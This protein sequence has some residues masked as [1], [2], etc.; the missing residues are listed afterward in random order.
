MALRPPDFGLAGAVA[1]ITGGGAGLGRACAEAL[2]GCGSAVVLLERDT[3]RGEA[4]A[5]ALVD[6][7]ADA[8]AIACDVREADQVDAAVDAVMSRHGRVSHLVNNAGGTIHQAFTE[9]TPRR[10]ESMWRENL[11]SALLTTRAVAA[12]M[13]EGGAIVNVTTIEAHRAAPDFAVY[14]ACKSGLASLT[15]SLA[16]ELAPRIR[17]NA[18]APDLIVTE[19]LLSV[20][21]E[22]RQPSGAHIP[23]QR[24]GRPEELAHAVLFLLSPLSSYITGTT[25]HVDGGTLAAGGWVPDGHGHYTLTGALR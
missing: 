2:A 22:G 21:P 19:G 17:V 15:A 4:A 13:G 10:W 9:S 20:M 16:L 23:L 5:A 12:H 25:I 24:A 14:A 8:T 18:V 3:A 11:L 7:G 1:V 6:A